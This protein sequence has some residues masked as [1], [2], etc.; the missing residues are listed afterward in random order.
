MKNARRKKRINT[1]HRGIGPK[2]NL[3]VKKRLR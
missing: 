3:K 2:W 1:G